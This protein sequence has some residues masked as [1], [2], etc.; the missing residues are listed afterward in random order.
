MAPLKENS[1]GLRLH[2]LTLAASVVLLLTVSAFARASDPAEI[3]A[4]WRGVTRIQGMITVEHKEWIHEAGLSPPTTDDTREE[5]TVRFT[6]EVDNSHGTPSMIWRATSA[7]I[8]GSTR[9]EANVVPYGRST[10][11]ADYNGVPVSL[12]DFTLTLE[13]DTG[14]WQLASPGKV[15]DKYPVVSTSYGDDPHTDTEM[16]DTVPSALFNGTVTGKPGVTNGNYKDEAL[17]DHK[18]TRGYTKV[19]HI[20]FWPE[21]DDVELEVTIADYAKWRPLG[22]IQKPTTPGNSL[23]ARATLKSKGGKAITLPK[24]KEFKF[25][26]LDTSREPGVCLNW[27]LAAKDKDYDLR[28]ALAPSFSGTLSDNDQ[29]LTI[30]DALSDDKNQ[31]YTE[32]KLDSYDFGAKSELQVT[33]VLDDGRELIG[34]M[35]EESGV[36]D[37]VR[38]PKRLGPDWIAAVWRTDNKVGKRDADDDEEKVEGQEHKGDGYTLYEEYRG[39]VEA[40]KHIEGDPEKKDFFVLNAI[41][42]DAKGGLALFARVSK[43]RV[44]AQLRHSEMSEDDRLMNGNHR[45][46]PHAVDQHGVW[47]INASG[48]GSSGGGTVGMTN[49]SKDYAF[50]PKTVRYVRV[51]V[52]GRYDGV[53]SDTRSASRY[54]LNERDA[55]F[56]YDR[57]VAHELLHAAG[58]DHHGEGERAMSLYF[59]SASDPN[60][61][62]HRARFVQ[63]VPKIDDTDLTYRPDGRE[64]T[65]TSMAND[66][67]RGGTTTLIW[68]DTGRDVA[69]GMAADFER[70][71]AEMR[72]RL[73]ADKTR[74]DPGARASRFAYYGKDAHYWRESDLFDRT[75]YSGS[76]F[77]LTVVIGKI[78]EADSGNELCLMRYYF[79]N[80]YPVKGKQDT[81]YLVRPN[82][83]R[84][85]REVCKTPAGTG[86]N[87]PGH[88]P[89][90][91]FGDS[92]RGRGNCF[93]QICPN[94]AIPMRKL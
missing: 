63:R 42:A 56:A 39:W 22:S 70:A 77:D 14:V 65:P 6:M 41:G 87:A 69:E 7:R 84:A 75:V 94:D 26:L 62:T 78:G 27:P 4:Q 38:L 51:E 34:E 91:R 19:A 50:R 32:A 16:Q 85:G 59:Q 74:E 67:D 93:N 58:V 18:P 83:N 10:T 2:R 92:A 89:Q 13:P 31:P 45:D 90:P 80:A 43:L 25:K 55:A 60:N 37:I 88:K 61:P 1:Q 5:A 46:G 20:Q 52:S 28:L 76:K 15:R 36:Q 71:L 49:E 68:E 47:L 57:G 33:A 40:G 30:T 23:V 64:R 54:N 48:F 24:V 21:F 82:A 53:F 35:K 29:A 81:Y 66:L 44:H 8:T 79:A 3:A 17:I 72:A 11:E 12:S 9:A 86:A 73:A